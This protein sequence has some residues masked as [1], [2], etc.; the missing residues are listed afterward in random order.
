MNTNAAPIAASGR[1]PLRTLRL[2]SGLLLFAFA[3]FH[4]LNHALLLVSPDLAQ[5]FQTAR[6]AV[7]R[8]LLGETVLVGAIL[9]HFP[10]GIARFLRARTWRLGARNIIQLLFGLLI[11]VILI[12]HVMGTR[13]FHEMFGIQDNYAWAFWSMWPGSALEQAL[14]MVLVWVHG[15]IGLHQWLVG[16]A[17]YR[18]YL[19]LFHG[20][21][22]LIPTLSY[23]G[24]VT[25]AR[26]AKFG[27]KYANPFK[28]GDFHAWE[29]ALAQSQ[30]IYWLIL[31]AA[32]AVWLALLVGDRLRPRI[33]VTY[34]DRGTVRAPRGTSVLDVSR[35]NRIPHAS[36]C[37]G[38]ARC[39]TC[40]VRVIAGQDQLPAATETEQM[41]LNRVGAPANVRLACQ[42]R[43]TANVTV[44]T[45][46]PANM[47]ATQTARADKYLWGVEQDVTIL[48]CDIRGFT[49]MS[50]GRL[51]FDVVF[52]L[53]Q[54]LG[55]MA[56]AIEDTGGFVDKFMG[57]GIM[58][59]FGMDEPKAAG[60]TK[61]IAAARA[62]GGALDALNQSLREEL[63]APLSM[64]VGLHTGPAILGRIGTAGR[65]ETLAPLTALGATVN[66]A[67]RLESKTKDLAVQVVVSA[68][69]MAAAGLAPGD[70]ITR[71][72]IEVRGLSAPL[73]VYTGL[74]ATDLPIPA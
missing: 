74:R 4:F 58:A 8:S 43:P 48:F 59:I 52:L 51:S 6:T 17:W 34:A 28:P 71:Q 73:D 55:K 33:A 10:L 24:F 37:G 5:S 36:V 23:A 35:M 56:E 42:L 45:L 19:W 32:V 61:A 54:F 3:T 40:R 47:D 49:T 31:G 25:A 7:T 18:R 65:S 16:K 26:A 63:P 69:C 60:A 53:N 44:S 72:T 15:C 64:G 13:G 20:A 14:L 67:S 29:I 38:R 21:A 30:T 57:D 27:P 39:S 50:E 41:V 2:V 62:M 68:D 1:I 70:R 11:P 12:R 9:I 66:L 46:L 22:V